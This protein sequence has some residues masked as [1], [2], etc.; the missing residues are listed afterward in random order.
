MP[1]GFLPYKRIL[2]Y[3]GK[4]VVSGKLPSLFRLAI[5]DEEKKFLPTLVTGKRT[6]VVAFWNNQQ[7]CC[8]YWCRR[9]KTFLVILTTCFRLLS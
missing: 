2:K 1:R 9:Y 6:L 7:F 8:S 4:K 5:I 3:P